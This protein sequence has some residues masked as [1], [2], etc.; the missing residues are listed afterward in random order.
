[1]I[2]FAGSVC[3][4]QGSEEEKVERARKELRAWRGTVGIAAKEYLD[5][6]VPRTYFRQVVTAADESLAEREKDLKGVVDAAVKSELADLRRVLAEVSAAMERED[7]A[8][9]M[10]AT[11]TLRVPS[12]NDGGGG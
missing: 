8:G 4:C 10:R 6:R 9:V 3:G 11:A 5:G 7:G 1:M 12:T 2:L